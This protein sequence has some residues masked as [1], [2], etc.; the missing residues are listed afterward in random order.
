[1]ETGD[2]RPS[3]SRC[4]S[5]QDHQS[6]SPKPCLVAAQIKE[7][8]RRTSPNGYHRLAVA[9]QRDCLEVRGSRSS[10]GRGPV[11]S[12]QRPTRLGARLDRSGLP[13]APSSPRVLAAARCR[14]RHIDSERVRQFHRILSQLSTFV[15]LVHTRRNA[16]TLLRLVTLEVD[17]RTVGSRPRHRPFLADAYVCV[18]VIV[19]AV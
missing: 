8:R 15:L 1:M 18:V 2:E 14:C 9:Q 4:S 5:L 10:G 16:G 19:R 17:G 7:T 13:G 11:P 6:H 3:P 12:H